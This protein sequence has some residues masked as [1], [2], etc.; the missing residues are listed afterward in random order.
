MPTSQPGQFSMCCLSCMQV[1]VLY[2]LPLD[3]LKVNGSSVVEAR[4]GQSN[5]MTPYGSGLSCGCVEVA[6]R[7]LTP[8]AEEQSSTRS[9]LRSSPGNSPL[10]EIAFD[11]TGVVP[12]RRRYGS[13]NG[14]K[15]SNGSKYSNGRQTPGEI[16]SRVLSETSSL[17]G[18]PLQHYKVGG[19]FLAQSFVF[20]HKVEHI[21]CVT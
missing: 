15:H 7:H 20:E 17:E 3:H 11:L 21:T 10:T 12:L 18:S 13:E 6:K 8:L 5:A 9:S 2:I 14:S 19:I 16:L 1:Q 4:D